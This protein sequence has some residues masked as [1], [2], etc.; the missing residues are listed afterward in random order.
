MIAI[1]TNVLL[2]VL[3]DDDAPQARTAR[4]LLAARADS[5][6][7]AFVNRIVLCEAVWTLVSGYR[8]SRQ[9]VRTAIELLL[10]A[11]AV[12]LE[13]HAAVEKALTLYDVGGLGFADALIGVVNRR[14]GCDTTYTFDRRAAET[15]DFSPVDRV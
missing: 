9:Q 2:R 8:Y 15:A 10:A 4:E 6:Q 13:D 1:D 3:L 5:G 7:P 11:P 14:A 12:R